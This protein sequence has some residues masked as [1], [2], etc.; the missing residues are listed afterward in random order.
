MIGHVVASAGDF[1]NLVKKVIKENVTGVRVTLH[2]QREFLA[3]R[4]HA[5]IASNAQQLAH[6]IRVTESETSLGGVDRGPQEGR[7]TVPPFGRGV[8]ISATPGP[9]TGPPNLRTEDVSAL[10]LHVQSRTP[11][12]IFTARGSHFIIF[13]LIWMRCPPPNAKLYYRTLI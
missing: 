5:N 13:R 2:S 3:E 12:K 11:M 4:M 10:K 9:F 6:V 8:F 1:E 7:M